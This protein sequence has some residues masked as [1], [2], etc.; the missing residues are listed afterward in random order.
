MIGTG[1]SLLITSYVTFNFDDVETKYSSFAMVDY[2]PSVGF[3]NII[4]ASN[5]LHH[6][7]GHSYIV[8]NIEENVDLVFE[9]IF[10]IT[11]EQMRAIAD[12][13]YTNP[14]NNVSP[15]NGV[16]YIEL[17]GNNKVHFTNRHWSG[18]GILIVDGDFQM[19]GGTFEGIVWVNGR[20]QIAG[21]A[22]VRGSM[23]VSEEPNNQLP[24]VTGNCDLYYDYDIVHQLLSTYNITSKPRVKILSWDN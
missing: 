20:L 2:S 7:F 18:S 6:S 5:E 4:T 9:T 10:G 16:T 21:N 12:H 15:V 19:T 23:F 13:D 3:D 24:H 17:T 14:S 1:D 8:G 22:L 11:M